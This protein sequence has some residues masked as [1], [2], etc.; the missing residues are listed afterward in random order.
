MIREVFTEREVKRTNLSSPVHHQP[1]YC[2][3]N[4]LIYTPQMSLYGGMESHLCLLAEACAAAH[5]RVTM[6][7]T[8]NSL[9]D[10]SRQRLRAAGVIF[11]ELPVE[12]ERA[13]K[14]L[15]LLWLLLTSLR[16]RAT[17]WQVIYTNGQSGLARIPWLAGRRGT[18]IVHHHH[19]AASDEEIAGWHPSFRRAL[20]KSPELVACSRSTKRQMETT[21]QRH[22]V[23]FLPYLT[24]EILSSS[25]V[26][27][28][29]HP[30]D[31]ILNFG[32]VGRLVS[33]K[34]IE[35][36]CRLSKQPSLGMVRWHL[37]GEGDEYPAGYFREFP[38]VVFHGRYQDL[39]QY[40]GILTSLDALV[41]LS[42][43]SEGMPLSLIEALAAGL[44][45]IATD[46]GGTRE[47]AVDPRNCIVIPSDA[48][49]DEMEA[50][51][52]EL[53]RRIRS[54]E[55]SRCAQRQ[56]YDRLFSPEIVA[57]QWIDFLTIPPTSRVNR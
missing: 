19:T 21:L 36:L 53:V 6:I 40:A 2:L 51:T 17:H 37:H 45:W 18:R 33:T 52:V 39:A 43:H 10:T 5:H 8:S 7:T 54:G 55:T 24:P 22:D 31:A 25:S 4:I 50:L 42:R 57:R 30:P 16:L 38:N 13:S 28:K 26:V 14:G 11:R 29:V 32:F 44:P 35:E 48:T 23:Q 41:L 47:I 27:E 3:S 56:V 46:R 49:F 1:Q 15:K 20:E 9:N 34:G 12:R